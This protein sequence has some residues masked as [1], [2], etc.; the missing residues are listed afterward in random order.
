MGT[1]VQFSDRDESP[2]SVTLGDMIRTTPYGQLLTDDSTKLT[3]QH[4]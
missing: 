3:H 4:Q 1:N 2:Y